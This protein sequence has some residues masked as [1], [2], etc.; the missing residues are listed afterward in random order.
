MFNVAHFK[1]NSK[2][3]IKLVRKMLFADDST[4]VAHNKNNL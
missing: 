3:S 1:A 4:L 2:T